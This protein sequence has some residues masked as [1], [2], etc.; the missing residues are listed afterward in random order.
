MASAFLWMNLKAPR[1]VPFHGSIG[2]VIMLILMATIFGIFSLVSHRYYNKYPESAWN[3]VFGIC[4]VFTV[5]IICILLICAVAWICDSESIEQLDEN[6]AISESQFNRIAPE[7]TEILSQYAPHE[8][9]IFKQIAP[10]NFSST[11]T[12]YAARYPELKADEIFQDFAKQ[13]N[14]LLKQ[15]YNYKLDKAR[16]QKNVRVYQRLFI[17]F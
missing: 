17:L 3:L 4:V 6:I 12:V 5:I 13:I 7:I 14:E 9:S 1:D 11:I 8:Q 10:N 2:G 16:I 15:I